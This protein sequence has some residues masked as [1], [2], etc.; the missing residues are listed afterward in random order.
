MTVNL[1]NYTGEEIRIDKTSYLGLPTNL[2][3]DQYEGNQSITD[4]S[5]IISSATAP[6]YNYAYVTEYGRYYFVDP[7]I[8]I[9]DSLWR[10]NLHVDPLFSY[11]TAIGA[12][13]GIIRYS[14]SGTTEISDPRIAFETVVSAT[15]T[16][17]VITDDSYYVLRYW[18]ITGSPTDPKK[19]PKIAF[20]PAKAFEMFFS[21][22]N[23][24]TETSRVIVGRSIIDVSIVHYLKKS[25]IQALTASKEIGFMSAASSTGVIVIFNTSSGTPAADEVCYLLNSPDDVDDLSYM[26]Y[27]T[28]ATWT[29]NY[30][31]NGLAKWTFLL[32]FAGTVSVT[33]AETGYHSITYCALRVQYE[34]YENAYVITPYINEGLELAGIVSIPVQTT[35]AFPIDSSFDN[36][37]GNRIA[38]VLSAAGTIAGGA[39]M[40]ATQN[41]VGGA[42]AIAGGITSS[43]NTMERLN[44]QQGMVTTGYAGSTGGVPAFTGT[45]DPTKIYWF[46]RHA[47]PRSGYSD[48]WSNYGKP[49]GAFRTLSTLTGYVQMADV[50][51]TGMGGISKI[52]RDEI[53]RLLLSGVI[54]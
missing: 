24:L 26:D 31:W 20:F 2:T 39:A 47:V 43:I 38:T 36:I 5:I 17:S 35:F 21:T 50:I 11:K 42:L 4:P 8:W 27:D 15:T 41:Y 13:K 9:A 49:D 29:D 18:R 52:E 6:T 1:Y 30:F 40:I 34:P 44:V 12:Q 14:G 19:T 23:T 53:K 33:P 54:M 7:P 28:G 51:L 32:P 3:G 16:S 25:A 22:Y 37:S 48:I 46:N 10:L 45:P